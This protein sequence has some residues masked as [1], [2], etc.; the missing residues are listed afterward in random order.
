MAYWLHRFGFAVTVLEKA[1]GV[2]GGGYPIDVRGAAVEVARRMGILPRLREAHIESR[3][4]TFL[5][6][7]GSVAVALSP[8][9]VSGGVQGRDI[10]VPRGELTE[11]L[12]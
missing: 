9:T 11:V 1:E 2:R 4:M 6:A 3:R 8:H 7:D 10:E 12:F 5:E